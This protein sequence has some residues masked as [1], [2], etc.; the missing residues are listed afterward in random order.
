[1]WRVSLYPILL[2]GPPGEPE[3]PPAASLAQAAH[4]LVHHVD[5]PPRR[6]DRDDRR[7]VAIGASSHVNNLARAL[8]RLGWLQRDGSPSARD[9][10]R[11]GLVAVEFCIGV[12]EQHTSD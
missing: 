5:L 9:W 3:R 7:A 12:A 8:R 6:R 1:M 11:P 2:A 10:A 4:L